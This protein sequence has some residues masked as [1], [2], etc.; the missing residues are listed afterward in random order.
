MSGGLTAPSRPGVIHSKLKVGCTRP[1]TGRPGGLPLLVR[2]NDEVGRPRYFRR[3]FAIAQPPGATLARARL[4]VTSAGINKLE[5]NGVPVGDRLLAPGWSAYRKRLRYDTYDVTDLIQHGENAIGAIVADGWWSGHLS[6]LMTRDFYGDRLGLLAQL[7]VEFSDGSVQTLV[8]DS[9]WTSNVGPLLSADLYNGESYDARAE[10]GDWTRAGYDASAWQPCEI[11]HP[12]VGNLEASM[13]PPIRRTDELAVCEVIRTPSGKTV[14]DFGQNLVGWVRF[15]VAG[16]RGDIVTLRHA[17]V[18]ED[19][20][21]GTRTLR[22]ARATDQYVLRGSGPEVWEP[23]FTFHGFRYVEVQDWPTGEVA[24]DSFTAV[25][26]H[27]D[28]ERT[29]TFVCSHSLI[30]QL[31]ENVVWGMRG[32]FVGVPTDC[33]QRDERLGWTGDLQVFA[34]TASFLFDVAG[35][36]AEWLADLR[37][38]QSESGHVPLVIPVG[39]LKEEMTGRRVAAVWGDAATIVPWIVFERFGDRGVLERQFESMRRWVELIRSRSDHLLWPAEFQLGDWLD[40]DAPP[41]APWRAKTDGRLIGTAYFARSAQIVAEA[42]LVLGREGDAREYT[43]LARSIREAFR[44]EFVTPNG[45]ISSN[46]VTAYSLAVI[47]ELYETPEQRVRAG[48][49]LEFLA[50]FLGYRI[51]TGFVGTPIALPAL[52]ATGRTDTAY[53]MLTETSCPSWLY[54]VTMGATTIWE[55]WDSML[56]DGSINSGEMTSFNHYAL[57][58][59]ADWMHRTIG[60]VG[61][62]EPGYRKIEIAPIPG[63]GVTSAKCSI[64]TPYGEASCEWVLDGDQMTLSTH[65]PPNTTASVRRP[66]LDEPPLDVESGHHTWVYEVP[67]PVVHAMDRAAGNPLSHRLSQV[68]EPSRSCKPE[69]SAETRSPT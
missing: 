24:A 22:N 3:S 16:S 10:L 41:D 18:M 30:N 2:E 36:L 53:R 7:E 56:P 21:L 1:M 68:P 11:F 57:G 23:N 9:T 29:G 67:D 44:R 5:L 8:T 69:D 54:P 26:I 27:S 55:R 58:S 19:G 63:P 31:H 49:L 62:A 64:R 20:E 60:G 4:Y 6:W 32:N 28:F 61:P 15:T 33:P 37:A 59:V 43:E 66:G 48:D 50:Q 12:K 51:S 65:I 39:P 46:T 47:F 40:P 42:A 34:P 25:V 45:L 13:A 14:L 17:E 35:F 38:E 52:T